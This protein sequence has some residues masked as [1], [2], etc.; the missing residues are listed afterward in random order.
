MSDDKKLVMGQLA[1]MGEIEVKELDG[2]G[3]IYPM[4]LLVT[5]E[6]KEA[7]RQAI[8]DGMCRFEF[9]NRKEP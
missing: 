1:I 4:A 6:D 3:Y 2:Q 5:F 7:I 8:K 9:M